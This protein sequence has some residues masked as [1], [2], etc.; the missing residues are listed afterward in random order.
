MPA[1]TAELGKTRLYHITD[2][3]NLPGILA[4][5]GLWSDAQVI[6]QGLATSAIAHAHM[7]QRRLEQYRVPCVSNRFVG[8]FVPFYFCSRAPMLYTI[9]SGNTG[10]P[11][12]CQASIVHLVST[13]ERA[14]VMGRRWAIADNNAGSALA[15]FTTQLDTLKALDWAAIDAK[16][17]SACATAKAAEFLV[18]DF[19]DWSGFIGMACM[20]EETAQT[21]Q[22]HLQGSAHRP[23]VIVKR[24]WY[25][26]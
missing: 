22:H 14:T 25:Y 4:Q 1:P 21:A 23:P 3:A 10:R 11:K 18:A 6:A 12:G 2:V 9:N 13:V 26:P 17:W 8:E 24:D 20:N 15:E 16:Y 7:K 19:F 5:G